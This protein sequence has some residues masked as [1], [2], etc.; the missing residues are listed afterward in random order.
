MNL[1]IKLIYK[2][3]NY[4]KHNKQNKILYHKALISILHFPKTT[5][6]T[7]YWNAPSQNKFK[8]KKI[9]S[10]TGSKFKIHMNYVSMWKS[11]F[12]GNPD[13][14]FGNNPCVNQ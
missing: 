14:K 9:Y 8:Q 12:K 10:A 11:K 13:Q 2:S 7:L 5:G 1:Q 6:S 4:N 3:H